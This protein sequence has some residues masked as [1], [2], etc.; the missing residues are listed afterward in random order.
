MQAGWA[1][2]DTAAPSTHSVKSLGVIR[3]CRMLHSTL[4]LAMLLWTFES[5]T[6]VTADSV[7]VAPADDR[8]GW[9]DGTLVALVNK[10]KGYCMLLH[11]HQALLQHT[12]QPP[13]T[14]AYTHS[15]QRIHTVSAVEL[16]ITHKLPKHFTRWPYPV[17]AI[18]KH[19]MP[20]VI[21]VW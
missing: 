10:C 16:Q 14:C 8:A 18:T 12:W 15:V 7:S 1:W 6:A 20:I 5:G 21:Y 17:C 19:G 11:M 4:L 3:Q 9:G 13:S 2:A